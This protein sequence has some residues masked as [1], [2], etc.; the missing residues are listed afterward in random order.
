MLLNQSYNSQ[1][2]KNHDNSETG[3]I[4]VVLIEKMRGIEHDTQ[5]RPYTITKQ[6]I[7]VFAKEKYTTQAI[8]TAN[9]L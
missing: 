4:R 3:L 9:H 1:V 8:E 2:D 6:G 7:Q 5:P